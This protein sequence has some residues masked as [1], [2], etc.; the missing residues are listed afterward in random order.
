MD[1]VTVLDDELKIPINN[2][3]LILGLGNLLL[4]DEGLGVRAV[5]R[6]RDGYNISEEVEAL[7]GGTL[8]LSLLPYL[9]GVK[10][11]LI[12]DAVDTG[13]NPGA[14]IRLE[15]T[16]IPAALAVKLSMHQ[17]GLQELLAAGSISGE[18]PERIVLWGIQPE[19][20]DWGVGLTPPVEAALDNL[21]YEVLEELRGWGFS[22][23]P[24]YSTGLTPI[25]ERQNRPS[26]ENHMW[27]LG[28]P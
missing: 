5:E 23:L 10:N 8:G 16:A 22:L 26:L 18:L 17:I 14:L 13:F 4:A 9:S 3:T 15:G 28:P 6:L 21:V 2:K 19:R 7:D 24:A 12:L 1:C 27:S 11:L 20:I 25:L